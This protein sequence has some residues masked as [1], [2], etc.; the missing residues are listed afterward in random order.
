MVDLDGAEVAKVPQAVWICMDAAE[1]INGRARWRQ[2]HFDSAATRAWFGQCMKWRE[3]YPWHDNVQPHSNGRLNVYRFMALLQDYLKHDQVIVTDVGAAVCVAFQV[4]KFMPTQRILTSGG[5]GE[6]G[7]GL[8][9]AIGA[10]YARNRG[11]VLCLAGDGGLMLNLQEL[12]TI[13]HN[14]LPIKII[15]FANDG[16]AMIKRTQ[17]NLFLPYA[18]VDAASG[19]SCVDARKVAQAVGISAC[20]VRTWSDFDQAMPRLMAS[21]EPMLMQVHI[22]PEQ[23]YL[24]LQPIVGTDGKITAPKFHELSPM[25]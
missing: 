14:N 21:D 17:K 5:L 2:E 3:Q 23:E 8:P 6:M 1:F 25:R 10:S 18:G 13:A 11:E 9:A 4:L 20:D 19:V 16:Y 24:K 7:C 12:Q 15:V 22:D